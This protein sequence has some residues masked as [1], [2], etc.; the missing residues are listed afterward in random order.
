MCAHVW[1]GVGAMERVT[2]TSALF[3]VKTDRTWMAG[4][5]AWEGLGDTDKLLS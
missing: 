5:L 3:F 1:E 2:K 4:E